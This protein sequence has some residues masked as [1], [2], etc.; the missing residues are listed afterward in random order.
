M[1]AVPKTVLALDCS[2]NWDAPLSMIGSELGSPAV[3]RFRLIRRTRV[4]NIPLF[5][6]VMPDD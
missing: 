4:A 5:F 3:A 2:E 6:L 1:V